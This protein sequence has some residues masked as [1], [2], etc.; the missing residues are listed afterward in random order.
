MK[1]KRKEN[2]PIGGCDPSRSDSVVN[3][4]F[5][6]VFGGGFFRQMVTQHNQTASTGGGNQHQTGC[7][8][9]GYTNGT[10]NHGCADN[11]GT[12]VTQMC[13]RLPKSMG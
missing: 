6:G 5:V 8:D 7:G 4:D 12:G 3:A 2:P 11:G 1:Y 10:H 13:V 9:G